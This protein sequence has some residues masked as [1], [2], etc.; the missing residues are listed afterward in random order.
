[1]QVLIVSIIARCVD[2]SLSLRD[3]RLNWMQVMWLMGA[4]DDV[5]GGDTLYSVR[6]AMAMHSKY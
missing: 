1:M 3:S 4:D 2:R 5:V 6:I